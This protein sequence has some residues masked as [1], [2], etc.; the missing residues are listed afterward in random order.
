MVGRVEAQAD[1]DLGLAGVGLRGLDRPVGVV[2][3]GDHRPLVD[4]KPAQGGHGGVEP[5]LL[6]DGHPPVGQGPGRGPEPL[7]VAHRGHQLGVVVAGAEP[8]ELGHGRGP[9]DAV[10]GQPDVA[11]ELAQGGRGQVAEDAVHPTGVEAEGAEPLLQLG[12]VVA[13]QHG[14]PPVEEAVPERAPGLDQGR[15]GLGAADAVDPQAPAVLEGLDGGPGAGPVVPRTRRRRWRSR[16]AR[17]VAARRPPAARSR[18]PPAG[19][20]WP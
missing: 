12:H 5:A 15:P 20:R 2:V 6:A 1:V 19:S 13:P 11:L 7:A 4:Q 3:G 8:E 14:R 10:D 18:R 17:G 9:G 16:G